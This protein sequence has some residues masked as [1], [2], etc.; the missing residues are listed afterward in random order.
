MTARSLAS[1]WKPNAGIADRAH[2][3]TGLGQGFGHRESAGTTLAAKLHCSATARRSPPP[4]DSCPCPEATAGPCGTCSRAQHPERLAMSCKRVRRSNTPFHGRL[5]LPGNSAM[6]TLPPEAVAALVGPEPTRGQ[7]AARR[8]L[9][10][11]AHCSCPSPVPCNFARGD[12]R[13]RTVGA[14]AA[15]S[16]GHSP[17][18]AGREIH[19]WQCC[20]EAIS[21]GNCA[22]SQTN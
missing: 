10:V 11:R 20:R 18:E 5:T 8:T 13:Q 14:T 19:C 2:F 17:L 12:G 21:P 9:S 6:D 16:P 4:K 22:N 15:G 3:Q 7:Q 1:L